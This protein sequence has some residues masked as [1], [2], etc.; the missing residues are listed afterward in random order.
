V[1]SLTRWR[2]RA[3]IEPILQV[4]E[5]TSN[6]RNKK[7]CLNA[8]ARLLRSSK[9]QDKLR[10]LYEKGLKLAE[11]DDE[12]KLFEIAKPEKAGK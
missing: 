3:A 11:S 2:D 9:S 4:A 8:A 6:K 12:R 10:P 1:R 7:L 5:Q